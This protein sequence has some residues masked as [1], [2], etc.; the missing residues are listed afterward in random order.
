MRVGMRDRDTKR[1]GRRNRVSRWQES[2]RSAWQRTPGGSRVDLRG[3]SAQKPI[4][5]D[6]PQLAIQV[7]KSDGLPG[8]VIPN[9]RLTNIV[10]KFRS[11]YSP[12]TEQLNRPSIILLIQ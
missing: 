8:N 12:D 1:L 7:K 4:R 9:Q 5:L 11:R 3:A 2:K 10:I 6:S